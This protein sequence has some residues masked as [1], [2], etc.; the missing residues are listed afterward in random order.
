M[1]VAVTRI[2]NDD[3]IVEAFVRHHAA[4]VDHHV[5]LDNGS[6]DRT[7]EILRTLRRDGLPITIY[8]NTAAVFAETSQNTLLLRHAAAMGAGWVL[9]LDCDEFIDARRLGQPLR[10]F[11]AALPAQAPCAH[12]AMVNYHPTAE[13]NQA[14]IVV[15]KRQTWRDPEP[16]GVHKVFV[17]GH[18]VTRGAIVGPGNHDAMLD[19]NALPAIGDA[20]LVLAHYYMRSGWQILAKAVIGRLKVLAAGQDAVQQN[21]SAHYTHVFENLRDHPEWLL[22][23]DAFLR[24]R[25]PVQSYDP[26]LTNDP[27]TYA[28]GPLTCT[29]PADESLKAVRSLMSYAETLARRYGQ[30]ADATDTTR[31]IASQWGAEFRDI[32]DP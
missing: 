6:T 30:L 15:P 14:E 3:D 10:D 28:G 29:E 17:R 31:R 12:A 27:I 18:A 22:H 2:R 20:R 26:P 8:G 9:H 5:F 25:R 11:L 7:L 16:G 32:T 19:G 4:L 1:L 13:D 24:A 21:F 23:D